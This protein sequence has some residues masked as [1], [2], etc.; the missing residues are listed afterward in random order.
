MYYSHSVP[1]PGLTD[2]QH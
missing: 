2:S 1:C